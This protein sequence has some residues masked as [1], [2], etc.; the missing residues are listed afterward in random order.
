MR[1]FTLQIFTDLSSLALT[2]NY[3]SQENYTLLTGAECALIDTELPST[4]LFHNLIVS[5]LAQEAI[6][7]PFGEN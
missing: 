4:V 1:S 7:N 6:N 3:P 5:S 2:N